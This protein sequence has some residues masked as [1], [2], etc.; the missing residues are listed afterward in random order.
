MAR[1]KAKA[2]RG[3][4]GHEDREN[5]KT[6]EGQKRNRENR[7]R[8]HEEMKAAKAAKAKQKQS[9]SSEAPPSKK[10]KKTKRG[11]KEKEAEES[12]ESSSRAPPAP[13]TSHNASASNSTDTPQIV[14]ELENTHDV[15]V[16]NIISSTQIEK[17]VTSALAILSEYPPAPS[18][19]PKVV[20]LHTKAPIAS[21]LITIAEIT[22]REI[23]KGGGKWFQYNK[24]GQ[25]A[26][27][28]KSREGGAKK[29]KG[30]G[31]DISMAEDGNEEGGHE[32]EEEFET[33]K[34]PFE[35]AIEGKPKIRA[36]PVL[37]LYLSRVRIES[38]R[39]E[40]T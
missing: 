8:K 38:L 36:T 24:L 35:R 23:V 16:M 32:S 3:P 11:A 5:A 30:A 18:T 25:I 6:P 39:R 28:K 37:T 17:K 4:A 13:S 15:T 21:K 19:K 7:K 40:Y 10:K 9:E 33:M 20:M 14:T 29:E 22:K 2:R 27:E 12:V 1:T 26:E 34:T 31:E